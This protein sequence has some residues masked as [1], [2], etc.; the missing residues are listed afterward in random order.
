MKT[1]SLLLCFLFVANFQSLTFGKTPLEGSWKLV[2]T[3]FGTSEMFP[4]AG[5]VYQFSG[6][7]CDVIFVEEN[8]VFE[9]LDVRIDSDT[10]PMRLTLTPRNPKKKV[11]RGVFEIRGNRFQWMSRRGDDKAFPTSFA[12]RE[13]QVFRILER[14]AAVP[15]MTDGAPTSDRKPVEH[16]TTP[17]KLAKRFDFQLLSTDSTSRATGINNEGDVLVTCGQGPAARACILRDGEFQKLRHFDQRGSLVYALNDRGEFAGAI[18]EGSHSVPYLDN[19]D[20]LRLKMDLKCPI[21]IPYDLNNNRHIVGISHSVMKVHNGFIW[22]N[23]KLRLLRSFGGYLSTAVAINDKGHVAGSA[24]FKEYQP[25][26]A[27][28]WVD[29]KP[30]DLGTLGKGTV[31]TGR[32]GSEARDINEVGAAVGVITYMNKRQKPFFY[33]GSKSSQLHTIGQTNRPGSS[34]SPIER[35]GRHDESQGAANGLNNRGWIVGWNTVGDFATSFAVLWNEG[36]VI[37]LNSLVEPETLD[38]WVLADATA[39]NDLGQIVGNAKKDQ[40]VRAFLLTPTK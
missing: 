9:T 4:G 30:V 13:G 18:A 21:L 15:K 32:L 11:A 38:G 22:E 25:S 37:D 34:A 17:L 6:N 40:V 31:E 14:I 29:R 24:N 1:Y 35:L 26:R 12:R 20:F 23:N 27:C 16:V 19:G 10:T 5:I 36:K 33:D 28:I 3:Q 7:K 8:E 39:V 2:S